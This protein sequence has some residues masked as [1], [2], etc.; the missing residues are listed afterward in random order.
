LMN[1]L[2][3][4]PE[5]MGLPPVEKF[6]NDCSASE[7]KDSERELS[8]KEILIEYVLRNKYIWILGISGFFVYIIRQAVNDWTVLYLVQ[9]KGYTKIAAGAVIF[10]FEVGGVLGSLTA[11]WASDRIFAAARGPVNAL[12]CLCTAVCLYGFWSATTAQPIIDS[13]LVFATGFFI[14]GP[15]MLIGVA[16]AEL[17]HK[18]AAA[19]ATGFIGWISYLGGAIAGY[20]LGLL[21]NAY[22]WDALFVVLMGCAVISTGMLLPLWNVRSREEKVL[23]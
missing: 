4:T 11:G 7:A 15:Q 8:V 6:R 21:M 16:A 12:F 9:T 1:R 13:L 5:S 23:A 3:D 17:S 10:W 14:F 19:T 20:P 22:G 2:A 18:K